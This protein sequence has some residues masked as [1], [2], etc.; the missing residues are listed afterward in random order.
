MKFV[1]R[2][3]FLTL[4]MTKS[5]VKTFEKR[6]AVENQQAVSMDTVSVLFAKEKCIRAKRKVLRFCI[7]ARLTFSEKEEKQNGRLFKCELALSKSLPD[8]YKRGRTEH[9]CA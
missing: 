3:T 7:Q 2:A 5:V 6:L 1:S 8:N 9:I 4:G